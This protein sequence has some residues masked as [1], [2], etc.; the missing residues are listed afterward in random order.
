MTTI[1][2]PEEKESH[3]AHEIEFHQSSNSARQ[4]TFYS[5]TPKCHYTILT[6]KLTAKL[7]NKHNQS[8]Q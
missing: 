2:S 6:N 5:Q 1:H 3:L 8:L 4:I 7:T